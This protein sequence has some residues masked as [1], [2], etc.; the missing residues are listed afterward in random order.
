MPGGDDHGPH[1]V[2]FVE[3]HG[4]GVGHIVGIAYRTKSRVPSW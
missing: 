4:A 3:D 2:E 1:A